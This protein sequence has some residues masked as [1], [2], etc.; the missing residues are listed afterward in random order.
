MTSKSSFL[1]N[2]KENHKRRAW[3]WIVSVL[4]QLLI[5]PSVITLYLSRIKTWHEEGAYRTEALF[6]TAM[7][8][9]TADA[10]GFQ[11]NYVIHI[12]ILGVIIAVQGFSYL[13][14]RKKVDMYKSVPV[15]EK[16][17]FLVIY[18]N[19]IL[20]YLIPAFA[21]TIL[22]LFIAGAQR[23]L[24]GAVLA[25]CAL[26]F[27]VN[28]LYFLIV[29]HTSMLAVML[30]GNIV[31]TGFAVLTF[32]FSGYAAVVLYSSFKQLFFD[33]VGSMF[34]GE[35]KHTLSIAMDYLGK[36]NLMKHIKSVNS[37]EMMG[38][39]LSLYAKWFVIAALILALSYW[40]YR[41]RP[42]EATG[43]AVTF[44]VIKPFVKV[45]ISTI[46]GLTVYYVMQDVSYHN[47][48]FSILAMVVGA[49]ICCGAMEAIYDFDIRSVIRHLPSTGTCVV[50]VITIFC[51]FRFD[52]FGYDTYIPD[53]DEIESVAV[54]IGPYQ[55][56]WEWDSVDESITYVSDV[57]YLKAN[58]FITDAEAVCELVKKGQGLKGVYENDERGISILYRLKSGREVS[59]Y[60]IVDWND[61]SNEEL[62]NRIVGT[63]EYRD[64]YYCFMKDDIPY[65]ALRKQIRINYTNGPIECEL[66][67]SC[68]ERL[69]D[70]W[71][72]DMEQ[73]DFSMAK[74]NRVCGV[75]SWKIG[76]S[77]SETEMP[78]YENFANTI[79]LLEEYD[80][81]YPI[82][83]RAEDIEG[84]E[85]TN[86]HIDEQEQA[87]IMSGFP[88]AEAVDDVDMQI[89]DV[90]KYFDEP[91]E[92][93]EIIAA[94]YPQEI[95]YY[96]N[97]RDM[98]DHNFDILITFKPGTEYPY[99]RGYYSYWFLKGQVPEFV[100][101][102][103]AR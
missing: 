16:R 57:S 89:K 95:G 50:I 86:Y 43:M 93:E 97:S 72:K 42:A 45:F 79:A 94:V 99:G 53:V 36:V 46:V 77:Y 66:P 65:D 19:G 54:D 68:A 48:S 60:F 88:E 23:A 27:L 8:N 55:Q 70:A 63:K 47:T 40:C 90:T 7:Y 31:V 80:A 58:M 4:T 22:A 73:F 96:W 67:S 74:H 44:P 91:Q 56:Y 12:L 37:A 100:V 84:I 14:D 85:I 75:I 39:V 64:G 15:P 87:E 5:Y 61:A 38:A 71:V 51:I 33:T 20:I 98:L 26:A 25:E 13:Y 32:L 10:L 28:L 52:V 34:A 82:Q 9:A 11:P 103:T 81:Y 83:L 3:V 17:R 102:R 101:E 21:G 62:L 76:S 6:R 1:V 59:R 2:S 35:A 49:V 78:V 92:I 18:V 30:T 24:N 69:R 41:K 29:Y